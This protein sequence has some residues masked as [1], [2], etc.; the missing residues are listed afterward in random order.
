MRISELREKTRQRYPE[1]RQIRQGDDIQCDAC[2]EDGIML[3]D[4]FFQV[5]ENLFVCSWCLGDI[6]YDVIPPV[7]QGCG[8]ARHM[9]RANEVHPGVY[10]CHLCLRT[11]Y[12]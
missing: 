8:K 9:T 6:E 7:C 4:I 10:Y 2:G 3:D 12:A 11:V 5:E 1:G